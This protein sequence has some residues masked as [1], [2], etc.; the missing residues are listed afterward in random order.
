ML[1]RTF[2]RSEILKASA[3]LCTAA[4][5]LQ[6]LEPTTELIAAVFLNFSVLLMLRQRFLLSG[7]FLALFSLVKI[8]LLPISIV[9]AAYIL[10]RYHSLN[11]QKFIFGYLAC[12]FVL[13]GPA[14][15]INGLGGILGGEKHALAGC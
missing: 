4:L 15:Y 1:T 14:L 7:A 3:L 12:L 10:F 9:I 6:F 2:I 8:E 11:R 13:V 5:G